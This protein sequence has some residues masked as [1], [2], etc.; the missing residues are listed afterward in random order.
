M[1]F[2]AKPRGSLT[3]I[4]RAAELAQI[5]S[6]LDRQCG[7]ITILPIQSAPEEEANR[8]IVRARKGLRRGRVRLLAG[9][10]LYKAPGG[11]ISD[12]MRMVNAG[13]AISGFG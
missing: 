6:V 9:L 7:E 13:G 12:D 10:V 3:I 8:V 11:D 1:I 5:L 2:A 4:H